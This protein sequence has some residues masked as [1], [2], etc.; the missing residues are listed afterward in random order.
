MSKITKRATAPDE[1]GS[2]D[3][4]LARLLDSALLAR[5]VPHLPAETLHR[6]IQHRG[7]EA[8]GELVAAMTPPQVSAL[9][10]LDLWHPT[11]AGND[12][13]F[14]V[15]RFG[16]WIETL[17]DTGA[18]VAARIV[19]AIDPNLVV[20]GLSRFVRVFDPGIFEPTA[21][22]D[23][24]R[25]DGYEAMRDGDH[26][27]IGEGSD[28][29]WTGTASTRERSDGLECE[30]GGYLVRARRADAWDAIVA[31][32]LELDAHYPDAFL[33]IMRGCR[34]L[35]NSRPEYGGL[36]DL[37]LE[38][39]QQLH[40]VAIDRERRR[41]EQGYATP[42]D[43]RAFLQMARTTG[44]ARSDADG[45]KANPIVTAYFRSVDEA[46]ES[47]DAPLPDLHDSASS[48]LA[49]SDQAESLDAVIELLAEAGMVPQRPRALL[50]A[51]KDDAKAAKLA[52]LR[53]AMEIVQD[54]HADTD[55]ARARE[56]AFLANVLVAGCSI[57]SRPFTSAEASDAAASICNLGLEHWPAPA[58]S[59]SLL[60]DHDLIAV[61]E[62][63][64]SVLHR[65]VGRY[66]AEQLATILTSIDC[67]DRDMR[68][69][70]D[71]LRRALAES[72]ELGMPWQ[73]RRAAEVLALLDQ[74]AWVGVAGLLD[75]CP[76]LPAA[77]RA[78]LEGH[79]ASV[80]TTG[81][82]FISTAAQID[83][84][85]SFLRKLPVLL[86]S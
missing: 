44:L 37:L 39:E 47:P 69:D 7:L 31:L 67:I 26:L 12:E 41:S 66:A 59:D 16:E 78:V 30:L 56:L 10:D 76:V 55:I 45:I 24:E 64:W 28:R 22:S 50:D 38:P 54:A 32:L 46:P 17:S 19:A 3:D 34:G 21:P 1:A 18:D 35:S 85:R 57:Q 15:D 51:P 43:A 72:L 81:F 25:G 13:L 58:S 14:D 29:E 77:V 75:E 49:A 11:R 27:E 83:E 70:I 33:K 20:A 36:D 40:D 61:F 53:R 71:A 4:R 23:D 60:I 48:L 86:S 9:L 80:D 5:V 65:D 63:G 82:E 8:S 2:V 52:H 84:V 79:T 42:G 74:A 73:A 68:R 62:V 6:L